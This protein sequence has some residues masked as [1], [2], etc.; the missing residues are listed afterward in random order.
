MDKYIIYGLYCPFTNK[1]HY[2]GKSS[3]GMTRPLQHLNKSHSEKIGE[4]VI[5][6]KF[7]GYKPIVKILEECNENNVDEKEK[8]WIQKAI[9]EGQYLLNITHNNTLTILKQKEYENEDTDILIIGKTIKD[10]RVNLGFTQNYLSEMA[11]IDRSTLYRIER[12][13]KQIT[14]KNLKEILRVLDYELIIKSK[15]TNETNTIS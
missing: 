10:A 14:I 12:G 7:I 2:V 9:D 4:W 11:G 8:I 6:L 3:H 15:N 13:N 5:Q 1:L